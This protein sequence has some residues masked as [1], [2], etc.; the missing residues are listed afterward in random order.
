MK[1]KGFKIAAFILFGFIL[2]LPFIFSF[3][4][5]NNKIKLKGDVALIEKPELTTSGWFDGSFQ[6]QF[7]K[8]TN[9]H[10]GFRPFFV[11][12]RNQVLYSLFNEAKAAGVIEGKEKYLFEKNYLKAYNGDDFLGSDSIYHRTQRLKTLQDSLANYGKTL[13]VCLAPGKGSFYPEYFP[14]NFIKP[15]TDSTNYKRYSYYLKKTGVNHLD[16]NKWFLKMKDTSQCIL[17][18]KY[19]IH[20]S[21]YGMVLATDSLIHHVENLVNQ[22]LPD[23]LIGK[24]NWSKKLKPMDYD[25]ADGM[26]LLWQ[27]PSEP[28][29]YPETNWEDATGKSQPK[30]ILI[31]DSF[32]WSMFQE[33]IWKN[34]FS[35]GGF[36]FY[37]RQI[38]PESFTDP[39]KVEDVNYWQYISNNDVFILLVTEANLPKFSWGFTEAALS[40]F[41]NKNFSQADALKAKA[42]KEKRELETQIKSIRSD[43]KWMEEIK[44]K[45]R[46]NNV[47]VD[48]M[49]VLD[50]KWM[51]DYR[52]K[53]QNK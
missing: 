19:G 6:N 30:T 51:I 10:V 44:R 25:I 47:S 18:P 32:Y 8:Y 16:F 21:Y 24:N 35:P 9:D 31:G 15:K 45:A 34:S 50:A 33:G 28:M 42:L 41:N 49:I 22:D 3:T 23:L 37:N 20:W 38:Y 11:C 43:K 12:I 46:K 1:R 14:D 36:W 39:L 5:L 48:S 52:R 4:N 27:L 2:L 13:L 7:E 17:Y 29:C 26:N 53:Q 40:S